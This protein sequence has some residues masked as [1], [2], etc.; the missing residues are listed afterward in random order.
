VHP[1]RVEAG[2]SL[3]ES[4]AVPA[5]AGAEFDRH[6]KRRFSTPPETVVPLPMKRVASNRMAVVANNPTPHS[7]SDEEGFA[8]LDERAR[9]LLGISADEFLRRWDAGE[10]AGREHSRG[11]VAKLAMLIPLARV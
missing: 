4:A 9:E 3:R 8:L 1:V 10:Y 7:V 11:A 6:R 2:V 5:W